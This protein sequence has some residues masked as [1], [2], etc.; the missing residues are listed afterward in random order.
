MKTGFAL[1]GAILALSFFPVARA[2]ATTFV[3][4]VTVP[5]SAITISGG[6]PIYQRVTGH[7]SM[8]PISMTTG[9]EVLVN[10]TF[11]TPIYFPRDVQQYKWSWHQVG[12][13]YVLNTAHPVPES[14]TSGYVLGFVDQYVTQTFPSPGDSYTVSDNTFEIQSIPEP[15]TWAMMLAGFGM[16]GA[17]IRS[18]RQVLPLGA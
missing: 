4:N 2:N 10:V 8:S 14:G 6:D 9:D 12:L 18:R 5:D 16:L 15:A 1:L 7:Y 13:L 11:E 17:M 3:A